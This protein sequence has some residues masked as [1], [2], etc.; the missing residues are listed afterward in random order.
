MELR[1]VYMDNSATTPVKREV[2]PKCLMFS[3]IIIGN[4]SSIHK[5]GQDIKPVVEKVQ[6]ERSETHRCSV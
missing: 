6:T 4:P 3:E 1:R 5:F 2:S